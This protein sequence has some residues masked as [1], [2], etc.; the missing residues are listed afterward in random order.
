MYMT[1][2]SSNKSDHLAKK[3]SMRYKEL[4]CM[5]SFKTKFEI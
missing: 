1:A 2:W 3:A 5:G 4:G